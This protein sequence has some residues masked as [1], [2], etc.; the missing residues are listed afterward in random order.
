VMKV[1]FSIALHHYYSNF[2]IGFEIPLI[3]I[4]RTLLQ[5]I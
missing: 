4:L 5:F 1:N 3:D 2:I